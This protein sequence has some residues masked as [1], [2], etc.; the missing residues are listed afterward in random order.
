MDV[1]WVLDQLIFID[2]AY[3]GLCP[4]Q[5]AWNIV[6]MIQVAKDTYPG[7]QMGQVVTSLR[8]TQIV[9]QAAQDIVLVM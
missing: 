2:D 6:I 1:A 4:F 7:Y 5:G 9:H 3:V 8:R